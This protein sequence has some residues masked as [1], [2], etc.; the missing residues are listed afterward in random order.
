MVPDYAT[1]IF[2]DRRINYALLMMV[3]ATDA[4]D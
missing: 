2:N 4:I 3:L 1:K